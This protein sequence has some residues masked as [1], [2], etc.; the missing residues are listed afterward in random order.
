MYRPRSWILAV[1]FLLLSG[2]AVA[3]DLEKN[4]RLL[5]SAD[6]FRV[7]TQAALAL[8]A[9]DD[10]K[11][12]TP[13]CQ[14]V[15]DRHRVV[16]IAS[17]T[18]LSRLG[19][20][21]TGCLKAQLA[22]ESDSKVK[23]ALKK[24]LSKL[25][26]GAAPAEPAIDSTTRFYIAIDELAGPQRLAGP[27]RAAFVRGIDGNEKVAIAPEDE[28]LAEAKKVLAKYRSAKGFMLS[29]KA[30]KPV[31]EGGQLKVKLSVAILTYPSKSIVG[32]FSQRVAMPGVN[33]RDSK[34][35]EEL[36]IMAAESA[37][38]KF[39]RIAPTLTR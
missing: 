24:A 39:L 29:A 26:G 23:A 35:E 20:G 38:K 2:V 9:S 6:D 8:G 11:A 21:G 16:R 33:E 10:N 25:L 15:G 27:V 7:R 12:V 5:R 22:K 3:D 36:V 4:A 18:G 31:Y 32:S 37:M 28:S 13:L 34:A 19:L 30:P 17:A 1:V 14:G